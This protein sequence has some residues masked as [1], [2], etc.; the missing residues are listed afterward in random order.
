MPKVV[1]QET[2]ADVDAPVCTAERKRCLRGAGRIVRIHGGT[3]AVVPKGLRVAVFGE[4]S[5]N[6]TTMLREAGVTWTKLGQ[7]ER[8]AARGRGTGGAARVGQGC[9]SRCGPGGRVGGGVGRLCRK[10]RFR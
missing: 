10:R 3:L 8:S 2:G 5:E 1:E 7:L 6:L 9:R 4:L